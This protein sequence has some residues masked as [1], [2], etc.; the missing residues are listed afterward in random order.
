[1]HDQQNNKVIFVIAKAIITYLACKIEISTIKRSTR[2]ACTCT[3]A[4][5][6]SILS[7]ALKTAAALNAN[8]STLLNKLMLPELIM[9]GP[10]NLK[11][12]G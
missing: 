8:F 6:Y 2:T 7:G 4:D 11:T 1:M 9:I 3:T 5:Q 12:V 10:H